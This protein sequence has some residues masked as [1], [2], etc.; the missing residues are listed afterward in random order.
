MFVFTKASGRSSAST[1]LASEVQQTY[2][3]VTYFG[4]LITVKGKIRTRMYQ[5]KGVPKIG[6]SQNNL[7][8]LAVVPAS[9]LWFPLPLYM[10]S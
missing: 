5:A 6:L 8:L 4:F 7:T 10:F 1:I 2:D 3:I 9:K